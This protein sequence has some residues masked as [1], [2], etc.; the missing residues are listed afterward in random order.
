MPSMYT[1]YVKLCGLLSAQAQQLGVEVRRHEVG[2]LCGQCSSS[3]G[4]F[5]VSVPMAAHEYY[6]SRLPA[7][8]VSATKFIQRYAAQ[9]KNIYK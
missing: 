5:P 8:E 9:N 2:N 3:L 4:R 6:K 7:V 1:E